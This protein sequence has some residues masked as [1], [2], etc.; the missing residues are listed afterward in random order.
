MLLA[1]AIMRLDATLTAE[2]RSQV[3]RQDIYVRDD[4]LLA[5]GIVFLL[6]TTSLLVGSFS[7]DSSAR[8]SVLS[9]SVLGFLASRV[10]PCR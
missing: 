3:R 7:R 9:L 8:E 5:A 1:R 2:K 4:V 6:K 10:L